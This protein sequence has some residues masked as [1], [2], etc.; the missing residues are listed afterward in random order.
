MQVCFCPRVV[1]LELECPLRRWDQRCNRPPAAGMRAIVLIS[2][3]GFM[4]A[5]M[6]QRVCGLFK[7]DINLWQEGTMNGKGYGVFAPKLAKRFCSAACVIA[8]FQTAFLRLRKKH[9]CGD[10]NMGCHGTLQ[11]CLPE[12][13][14]TRAG[15]HRWRG[16]RRRQ[17]SCLSDLIPLSNYH[18]RKIWN[19]AT[20]STLRLSPHHSILLIQGEA[21][22]QCGL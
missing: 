17:Q 7:Q 9:L 16:A 4:N 22:V 21:P 3:R 14:A 20:P 13:G 1:F 10:V 6:A 2:S 5:A 8:T 15:R 11:T 18:L 19:P 12:K